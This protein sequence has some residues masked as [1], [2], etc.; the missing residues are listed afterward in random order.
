MWNREAI[1]RLFTVYTPDT[2]DN[3]HYTTRAN[4]RK[5]S[6]VHAVHVR[7]IHACAQGHLYT[8]LCINTYVHAYVFLSLSLF[9]SIDFLG[10]F[11]IRLTSLYRWRRM[12]KEAPFQ[13]RKDEGKEA[14]SG[15]RRRKKRTMMTDE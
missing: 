9:L 1:Q 8:A 11:V 13:E 12:R 15:Q 6:A 5:Y 2:N 7:S 4:E 10:D 3:H 14:E